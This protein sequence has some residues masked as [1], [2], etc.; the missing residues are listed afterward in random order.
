MISI[1]MV[2]KTAQSYGGAAQAQQPQ[3]EFEPGLC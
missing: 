3:S 1:L 2:R